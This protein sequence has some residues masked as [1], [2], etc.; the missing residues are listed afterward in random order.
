V[1]TEGVRGSRDVV[2]ALLAFGLVEHWKVPPW[3]VVVAMAAA[4]QWLLPR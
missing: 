1:I 2:A 3:L 4:G